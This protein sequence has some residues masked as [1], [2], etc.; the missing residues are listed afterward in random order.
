MIKVNNQI[1]TQDWRK[2]SREERGKLIFQNGRIR[3]QDNFWVIGLTTNGEKKRS[4][5]F[6]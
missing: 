4:I 3:Q 5:R 2:L 6:G 1:Q